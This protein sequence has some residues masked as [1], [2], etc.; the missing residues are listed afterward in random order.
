M[1]PIFWPSFS[2]PMPALS[3]PPHLCYDLCFPPAFLSSISLPFCLKIYCTS[4]PPGTEK[5]WIAIDSVFRFSNLIR[6][7]KLWLPSTA[8]GY[9]QGELHC[10]QV[11]DF[12]CVFVFLKYLCLSWAQT[13]LCCTKLQRDSSIKTVIGC[14]LCAEFH[15]ISWFWSCYSTF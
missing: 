5:M 9:C 1:K 12:M 10:E 4:P 8:L 15:Q 11:C 3:L 7:P 13:F 6:G 2:F 14:M